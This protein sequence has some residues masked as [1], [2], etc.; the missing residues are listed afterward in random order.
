MLSFSFKKDYPTEISSSTQVKRDTLGQFIVYRRSYS[1]SHFFV[2]RNSWISGVLYEP[3]I[4]S[5]IISLMD[6][7]L[8]ALFPSID[9]KSACA[10]AFLKKSLWD[11]R[12]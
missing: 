4:L 1:S 3:L 9:L 6:F 8:P 12:K 11:E 10:I 5:P 7:F 2:T